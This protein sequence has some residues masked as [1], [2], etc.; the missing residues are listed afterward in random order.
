M[1]EKIKELI[2]SLGFQPT[3]EFVGYNYKINTEYGLFYLSCT[4][5]DIAGR[6][7]L[8]VLFGRFQDGKEKYPDNDCLHGIHTNK[9]NYIYSHGADDLERVADHLASL[10]IK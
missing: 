10:H 4:P 5:E 7:W 1:Y 2:E 9:Y 6:D 3:D 8:T